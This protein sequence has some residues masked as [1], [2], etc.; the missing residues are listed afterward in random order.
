MKREGYQTWAFDML[1]GAA[2][3]VIGV[4]ATLVRLN[5]LVV[6][7]N[8]FLPPVVSHLWPLLLIGTGILW[9][10]DSREVRNRHS[11]QLMRSGE[12]Q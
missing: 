7:W 6:R 11:D 9:L 2:I 5:L 8:T 4:A 1:V 3:V 10:L 12:R